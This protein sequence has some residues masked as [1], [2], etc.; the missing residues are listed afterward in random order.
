MLIA[1]WDK[2]G[3][4]IDVTK[5]LKD[6]GNEK[7]TEDRIAALFGESL[8]HSSGPIEHD[9]VENDDTYVDLGDDRPHKMNE[10]LA[11][12]LEKATKAG[13]SREGAERFKHILENID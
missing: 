10:E 7:E 4:A 3:D 11:M 9:G 13:M 5:R 6:D 12:R 2:Y 8:F 1:A